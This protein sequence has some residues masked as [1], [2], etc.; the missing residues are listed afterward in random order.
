MTSAIPSSRFCANGEPP[1]TCAA[2]AIANYERQES[3]SAARAAELGRHTSGESRILSYYEELIRA[4]TEISRRV[5]QIQVLE[6]EQAE[7]QKS[8]RYLT[9]CEA[10]SR[11]E[12][13]EAYEERRALRNRL[14]YAEWIVTI[15]LV[16]AI[17]YLTRDWVF[18]PPWYLFLYL[19]TL[20]IRCVVEFVL[21]VV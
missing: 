16:A 18:V 10:E 2:G 15:L 21:F 17:A 1:L 8:L 4:K 9:K 13:T 5:A 12:S 3:E 14:D 7:S 20:A 6:R 19:T 11:R